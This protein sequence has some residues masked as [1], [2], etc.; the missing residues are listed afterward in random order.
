MLPDADD[1]PS[2]APE[3]AGNALV[4]GQ[5]VLALL[6]PE[7][8][9]GFRAGVAFWAA[10]PEPSLWKKTRK[11]T[12]GSPKGVAPFA[13]KQMPSNIRQRARHTS[14]WGERNRAFQAEKNAVASQ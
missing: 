13:G 11:T 8:P 14:L 7:F 4:A 3:L 6:V 2:P 1:F 10:V 5:V 9:V 12:E